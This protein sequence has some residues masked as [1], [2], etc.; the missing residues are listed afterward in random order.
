MVSLLTC[1]EPTSETLVLGR[2]VD[3]PLILAAG[4]G[5]QD[6]F[7]NHFRLVSH[8]LHTD[9]HLQDTSDPCEMRVCPDKGGTCTDALGSNCNCHGSACVLHTELSSKEEL[10]KVK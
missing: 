9:T 1:C 4:V 3:G 7:D 6:A 5:L 10:I 8:R 2:E